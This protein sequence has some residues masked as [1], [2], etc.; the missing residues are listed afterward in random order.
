MGQAPT[1]ALAADFSEKGGVIGRASSCT[2]HLPDP[3]Q[4]ISREQVRVGFEGGQYFVSACGIANIVSVNG[5][6]L[7]KDDPVAVSAGDRLMIGEFEL[8]VENSA[9]AL[10]TTDASPPI[11]SPT[12]FWN[13]LASPAAAQ[14]NA[15]WPLAGGVSK[16]AN[17]QA[18]DPFANLFSAS[19]SASNSAPR[20]PAPSPSA[21]SGTAPPGNAAQAIPDDFDI[22]GDLP[23]AKSQPNDPFGL[24]LDKTALD[25]SKSA[26]VGTRFEQAQH[27][28]AL[29]LDRPAQ[30]SA[31]IGR[32]EN[33]DDLFGLGGPRPQSSSDPLG[34]LNAKQQ[35]QS[36]VSE[37]LGQFGG[38]LNQPKGHTDAPFADQTPEIFGTFNLP[39]AKDRSPPQAHQVAQGSASK[40]STPLPKT[41][42]L[43]PAEAIQEIAAQVAAEHPHVFED[44]PKT[45]ATDLLDGLNQQSIKAQLRQNLQHVGPPKNSGNLR[46]STSSGPEKPDS[47]IAGRSDD[48]L[49]GPLLSGLLRGL[50]LDK[51]PKT[52]LSLGQPDL[53]L[54]PELMEQIGGILRISTQATLDLL[55][56]RSLLKREMKAEVTMIVSRDNNPLKFSP[57]SESALAHLLS[58]IPIRGFL[59][60]EE[61]VQDAF[62]DLSA[63][64]MAFVAGMRAA[65]Q[66]LVEKFDPQILESRLTKKSMIESVV[67]A[68]R[69]A[70]LWERFSE[71]YA[72]ISREAEDDFEALFGREFV[73]AYESQ[74]NQLD[75][76]KNRS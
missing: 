68:T 25:P 1:Q 38:I 14:G 28:D 62:D 29:G 8:V 53:G 21:V 27:K 30:E 7:A 75:M 69:K 52:A 57:D 26:N 47:G 20:A 37:D 60:P 64:Q 48:A 3:Y 31:S 10:A 24:S 74:I 12:Q 23:G 15:G 70:K 45:Q 50:K 39:N 54:T 42:P 71:L 72:E 40:P 65:I 59:S 41:L 73:K 61:S 13:S 36:L 49:N 67:P 17:E 6:E 34:L 33:I 76:K 35:R 2:L 11:D 9:P 56:A 66:S 22:W 19:N 18:G 4:H 16:V 58:P 51:L 55:S 32:Q 63:H 5:R 46:P 43:L 44:T